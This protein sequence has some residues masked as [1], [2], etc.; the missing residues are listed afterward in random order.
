MAW[1]GPAVGAGIGA[2]GGALSGG[3]DNHIGPG[4]YV[5]DWMRSDLEDLYNQVFQL[6]TPEYYQGNLVAGMTPGYEQ[7][8]QQAYA[9]GAPGGMG[10]DASQALFG[11]GYAGLPGIGAGMDYLN[12]MQ[13]RGP[14]QF[15]F[16]QGTYD[17]VMENL[18]PGIAPALEA[19]MRDDVR[20][21]TEQYVPGVELQGSLG[22]D[23][24]GTMPAQQTAIGARGLADREYD[25]FADLLTNAQNQATE[26]AYGAGG[27]NLTAAQALDQ[28]LLSGYQG[29]GNMGVNTLGAGFDLGAQGIGMGQQAG[30]A[31]LGYDQSLIDAEMAKWDFEQSAPWTA[32]QNQMYMLPKFGNAM[33]ASAPSNFG[34]GGTSAAADAWQGAMAGLGI[35]GMGQDAGWWGGGGGSDYNIFG[36][37]NYDPSNPFGTDWS[38]YEM[39]TLPT[40]G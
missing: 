36:Q 34:T 21:F 26:A 24:W 7:A 18:L 19:G 23:Y 16:D 28:S 5:P 8:L 22:G 13:A 15:Q 10:Y 17:Q 3:S 14:N 39:P 27:A 20:A 35:Y 4:E 37:N 25:L 40:L 1:I 6:Q 31:D 11:A 32:L 12:Q 38:A 2:L 30:L 29:F 33:G 9:Y